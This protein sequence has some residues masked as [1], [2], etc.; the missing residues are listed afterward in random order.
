MNINCCHRPDCKD[1]SCPGRP[2]LHPEVTHDSKGVTVTEWSLPRTFRPDYEVEHCKVSKQL[3]PL[4]WVLLVLI[5]F[6]FFI[7]GYRSI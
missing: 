5:I 4:G 6:G 7:A 3:T 2:A 1:V